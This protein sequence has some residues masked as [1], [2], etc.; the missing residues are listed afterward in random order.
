[1][2]FRA[3]ARMRTV[4]IRPD[5]STLLDPTPLLSPHCPSCTPAG[6]AYAFAE[7]SSD[8]GSSQSVE[9]HPTSSTHRQHAHLCSST[10]TQALPMPLPNTARTWA[11]PHCWRATLSPHSCPCLSHLPT[12]RPPLLLYPHTGTAYA[13]AEYGS[14]LGSSRSVEGN[15]TEYYRKAGSGMSV[16]VGLKALGACRFE[17]A[18]DCNAGKNS[19]LINW[20]ERF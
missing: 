11:P 10:H 18:R 17:Y 12:T 7:Y 13:F 19:L 8:L 4:C 9:G 15:P 5:T 1:M 2:R 14:D 20:G 3:S 16:G 6:T